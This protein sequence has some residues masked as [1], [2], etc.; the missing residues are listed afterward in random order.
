[1]LLFS[2]TIRTKTN[3]SKVDVK[4]L[5]KNVHNDRSENKEENFFLV[6][7]TSR[8]FFEI[9]FYQIIQLLNIVA[10]SLRI[11]KSAMDSGPS[12]R[13]YCERLSSYMVFVKI[14]NFKY[15]F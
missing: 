13:N 15:N 3:Q 7:I 11:T 12:F 6:T 8:K 1:M 14:I 9:A 10:H 5:R 2:S 4:Y